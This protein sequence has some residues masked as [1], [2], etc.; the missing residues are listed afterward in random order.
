MQ[1]RKRDV[2][3]SSTHFYARPERAWKQTAFVELSHTRS[4]HYTYTKARFS[5]P[6]PVIFLLKQ[7]QQRAIKKKQIG[8][9][10]SLLSKSALERHLL[11]VCWTKPSA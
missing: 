11:T 6:S 5:S 10:K 7:Q 3:A 2:N 8:E 9:A 1:H 4:A